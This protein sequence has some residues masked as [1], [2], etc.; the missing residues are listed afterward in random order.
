MWLSVLILLLQEKILKFITNH[1]SASS[2]RFAQTNE[3][4][5][6]QLSLAR[7]ILRESA[8]FEQHSRFSRYRHHISI[9]QIDSRS[10]FKMS[11]DKKRRVQ[12][13]SKPMFDSNQSAWSIFQ[14]AFNGRPWG[15]DAWS[16]KLDEKK[17]DETSLDFELLSN[18]MTWEKGLLSCTLLEIGAI[19]GTTFCRFSKLILESD[20]T[21]CAT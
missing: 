13:S 8:I 16:S 15:Y 17:V 14:P 3:R 10:F 7:Q 12:T 1:N 5:Q 18:T 9:S 2:F 4:K 19:V 20:Y 6:R 11:S 21:L